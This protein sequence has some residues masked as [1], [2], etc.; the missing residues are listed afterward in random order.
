MFCRSGAE[1]AK[2]V[3]AERG[4]RVI[5]VTNPAPLKL[6][7]FLLEE[8]FEPEL[9]ELATVAGLLVA[10]ERGHRIEVATV[11]VDLARAD[12]ARDPLG[13]LDVRRPDSTGQTVDR[14][15]R[16]A[17]RVLLAIVRNDAEDWPEDLFLR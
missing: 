6:H 13:V 15:V 17:D 5:G 12:S 14:I 4:F 3:E 11:D 16:D 2:R 7:A 9:A 1:R 10:A 8:L